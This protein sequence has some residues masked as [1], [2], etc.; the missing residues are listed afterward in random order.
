MIHDE[1]FCSSEVTEVDIV[2][3]SFLAYTEL[4]N[5]LKEVGTRNKK[6]EEEWMGLKILN[7]AYLWA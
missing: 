3:L 5:V 2:C 6:R 4:E 1:C 7:T